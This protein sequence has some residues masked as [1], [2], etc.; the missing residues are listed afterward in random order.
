METKE[1]MCCPEKVREDKTGNTYEVFD[2]DGM[3][4]DVNRIHRLNFGGYCEEISV[5]LR[6]LKYFYKDC[7]YYNFPYKT[8]KELIEAFKGSELTKH[9][10]LDLKSNH[11]KI[12]IS[13]PKEFND[14][15]YSYEKIRKSKSKSEKIAVTKKYIKQFFDTVGNASDIPDSEINYLEKSENIK[16]YNEHKILST[17]RGLLAVVAAPGVGKTDALCDY[18]RQISP[19]MKIVVISFRCAL[20]EKQMGDLQGLGFT[21][22]K[23]KKLGARIDMEKVKRV[24]IQVDSLPRLQMGKSFNNQ[25]DD[26]YPFTGFEGLVVLDEVESIFEHINNS[27][28]ISDRTH[29]CNTIA[30]IIKYSKQVIALDANLS[31]GSI[32]FFKEICNRET[33]IYKNTYIRNKRILNILTNKFHCQEV[34]EKFL[35]E[36]KKVYIPTNSR[37]WGL[38][39]YNYIQSKYPDLR[40]KIY[41]KDTKILKGCDPISDMINYDCCITTPKF[42][43]GNSF[44]KDHFDLVCGYFSGASCSPQGSSQLLTRVRNVKDPNVYLYI[45]NKVGPSN[46]VIKDVNTFDDMKKY[47]KE[48]VENVNS[49]VELALSPTEFTKM[50]VS[51]FGEIDF[52]NA[53]TFL[54]VMNMY[55]MNEGYKDYTKKLMSLLK[56]MGFEF[57]ENLTPTDDDELSKKEEGE[58]GVTKAVKKTRVD[59]EKQNAGLISTVDLPDDKTYNEIKNKIS[60]G[61]EEVTKE[62]RAQVKKKELLND[63]KIHDDYINQKVPD[64]E[65]DN[66]AVIYEKAL[67]IKNS[68]RL[69]LKLLPTLVTELPRDKLELSLKNTFY[70]MGNY[71]G[72]TIS[73]KKLANFYNLNVVG[74]VKTIIILY[75]LLKVLGFEFG[76]YDIQTKDIKSTKVLACEY[77]ARNIKDVEDMF[78]SMTESQKKEQGLIKWLNTN[79]NMLD[80]RLVKVNKSSSCFK[81]KLVS[82]WILVEDET[83]DFGVTVKDINIECKGIQREEYEKGYVELLY[84]FNTG[85]INAMSYMLDGTK[86]S[87]SWISIDCRPRAYAILNIALWEKFVQEKKDDVEFMTMAKKIHEGHMLNRDYEFYL[88]KQVSEEG[89]MSWGEFYYK[90]TGD[91]T[92]YKK[93]LKSV[94]ITQK[95]RAEGR[96]EN[97]EIPV[98]IKPDFKLPVGLVTI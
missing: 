24:V 10:L 68:K 41:D 57:G 21:H 4:D 79:L 31:Y 44:T 89:V 17:L 91:N 40:V 19:D 6:K 35:S 80:I 58:K 82:N 11:P 53:S 56:G 32:K 48:W 97:E 69:M 28:H 26:K 9:L 8:R 51:I 5:I 52:M 62:E 70:D 84:K 61:I 95:D 72:E 36:G 88:S 75:S 85:F 12:S 77:L 87:D 27:K 38:T 66:I 92:V 86:Y 14:E 76:F 18:I 73:N 47:M 33:Y 30:N 13:F 46:K 16:P 81:Y 65:K 71:N 2:M 55:N 93:E 37:I 29:I 50:S 59:I 39:L 49:E 54:S 42:Q 22:Y 67:K 34:I 20:A 45:D 1:E 83:A 74:K 23:D 98:I 3:I 78:G 15:F 7:E 90:R 43:A 63:V 60:G 94:K 25:T 96:E 64:I